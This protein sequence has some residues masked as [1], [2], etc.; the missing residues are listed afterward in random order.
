MKKSSSVFIC[1]HPWLHF[2]EISRTSGPLVPTV[3]RRGAPPRFDPLPFF[4]NHQS[5]ISLHLL[6]TRHFLLPSSHLKL[7]TE[8]LKLSILIPVYNEETLVA[9]V[10]EKITRLELQSGV[11][12]EILVVDDGSRDASAEVIRR[13]IEL[14][15]QAPVRFIRHERNQGK[16]A[17]VRTAMAASTGGILI[18]QDA[19]L[20]YDPEDIRQ[21][22]D[23]ILRG[24]TM[25]VYGSRIL[26]E[27]A[28]GR[29]GVCGLITG[30]HPH[31]YALA[32]L[33]GVAITK[34]VN[35]L[36]G[37]TLTDEPTCYK[38]F[39]S[40]AIDGIR[41]KNDDFAWEPEITMKLLRKG[42]AIHEVPVNYHPRKHEQGKKIN[43]R[44][45]V[46]ALWTVW[47]YR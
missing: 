20:E 23:P 6:L 41:I 26:R 42:I 38:C 46:K 7:N 25:V 30:K 22:L 21:V 44:D 3:W 1:V 14:N 32:Y 45:G 11:E 12:K 19:D 8:H 28:L 37:A 47:R 10:L 16:G 2:L 31:S 5:P 17:A 29:S 36:T 18:I 34:S 4:P 15:P 9:Q 13:F 33:G 24:E 40:S 39:L 35:L 27:K 43:W